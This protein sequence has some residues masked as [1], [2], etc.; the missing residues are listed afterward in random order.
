MTL[1]SDAITEDGASAERTRRIDGNDGNALVPP[2]KLRD[3]AI[4]ERALSRSRI[5]RDAD[6]P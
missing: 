5:A 4:D 6:D 1:H 2:P 3:Q